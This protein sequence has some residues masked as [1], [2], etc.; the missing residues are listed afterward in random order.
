MRQS[1]EAGPARRALRTGLRV[2]AVVAV[3]AAL[4]VPDAVGDLGPAAFL[5]LPI[6]GI[7]LVA[8]LAVIPRSP[9]RL[10]AVVAGVLIAALTVA[11]ALD[12]AVGGSLGRPFDPVSDI[13]QLGSG[14][15]VVA[16][17][18][19]VPA[20]LVI[21]GAVLLVVLFVVA[22]VAAVLSIGGMVRGRRS[23]SLRVLTGLTAVWALLALTGAALAPGLPIAST[24]ESA[25]A[26]GEV[27]STVASAAAVRSFG[28]ALAAPDPYAGR[29]SALASGPLR[30]KDVLVVFVES[31][32][33]V[34]VQGTSFSRAVDATLDG[35]HGC[36][37]GRRLLGP[38]RHPR[39][40]HLRRHQLARALDAP[41][42][43]LGA[44]PDVVRPPARDRPAHP[45]A[46]LP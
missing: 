23:R 27:S 30:G 37:A 33:Q 12:A 21:A 31:Y 36:A 43:R 41:V 34:A 6:E 46:G 32:G 1:S 8:L 14:A 45:D 10:V 44:E 29:V 25:F 40:A 39:L 11:K 19:D 2:A 13:G 35:G 17:S 3:W 5:R 38:H 28:A 20:G 9:A 18:L 15:G 22:L 26:A 7:L 16:D 4:V 24:S 42:G